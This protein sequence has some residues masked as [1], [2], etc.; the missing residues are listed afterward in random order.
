MK[1]SLV[2]NINIKKRFCCSVKFQQTFQFSSGLWDKKKIFGRIWHTNSFIRCTYCNVF[3]PW[4]Q[5]LDGNMT[6]WHLICTYIIVNYTIHLTLLKFNLIFISVF[7][8]TYN[9]CNVNSGPGKLMNRNVLLY[10]WIPLIISITNHLLAMSRYFGE[11]GNI[12]VI[13]K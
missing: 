12:F 13:Y 3:S 10:I 7:G 5:L 8:V 9:L 1:P 11:C 4:V 6:L 2:A